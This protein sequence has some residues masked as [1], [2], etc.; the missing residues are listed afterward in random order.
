MAKKK[1]TDPRII[2][3]KNLTEAL[4]V[5]QSKGEPTAGIIKALG[6]LTQG[7]QPSKPPLHAGKVTAKIRAQRDAHIQSLYREGKPLRSIQGVKSE[8]S[9]PKGYHLYEI[10]RAINRMPDREEIK[11]RNL[12]ASVVD[13]AHAREPKESSPPPKEYEV[14]QET[15]Q[16]IWSMRRQGVVPAAIAR[17]LRVD[18]EVIDNVLNKGKQNEKAKS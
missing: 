4:L 14:D 10:L 9:A 6:A 8:W 15:V 5:A 3:V 2:A 12:R 13:I 1:P 17:H 7:M 11:R 18:R 16:V